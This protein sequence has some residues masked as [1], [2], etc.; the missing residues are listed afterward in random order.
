MVGIAIRF[1]LGRYH[2][3]PWG[4]HVN[5]AASEWP[6]SPW[7]LVR[8]LYAT[9]RTNTR[10][11]SHREQIDRGLATLIAAEPPVFELPPAFAAHTRHY[12]P[13]A[14]RS[15][16]EPNATDKVLDGF[17]AVDPSAELRAWWDVSLDGDALAG[18]AAA[19]HSL[20]YLGRSESVCSARLLEDGEPEA[21]AA[22][23]ATSEL[24]TRPDDD[25]V[26]LL[27]PDPSEPLDAIAVS[28]TEVRRQRRRL[29]PGARR[30]RYAVAPREEAPSPRPDTSSPTKPKLAVLRL[31][32][33][34]RPGIQ[35]AV[36]V[37]EALRSALQGLY[38]GANHGRASRTFSGRDGD[39]PRRDQHSH[40]HYLSLPDRHGRRVDRLVVWAPE[41]LDRDEVGALAQLDHVNIWEIGRLQVA[42]AA[43]GDFDEIVLDELIGPAKCWRSLT[44]FGLVRHPKTR[45]GRVI[46]SPEDQVRRELEH[47]GRPK[48]EEITLEKRSWHRFRSSKVNTPRL[49]RANLFG[50]TLRFSE[51]VMG[52]IALGALSHYGLGLMSTDD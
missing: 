27:C 15:S 31:A 9:A 8:A 10:L 28:I 48:P 49:G 25:M 18:L 40:A 26:E 13:K 20:G 22:A 41:G 29:P 50:V 42:L 4:A 1:D 36:A 6:P 24:R 47:R 46:D 2:A 30:V 45:G 44:P 12:M 51:P 39:S 35:E 52:P 37:G 38:G 11:A 33:S 43:L 14:R 7:R 16:A 17:L 21:V 19:A 3:N 23:P 32:G 5:D 34:R